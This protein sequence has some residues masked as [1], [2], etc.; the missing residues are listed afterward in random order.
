MPDT[1]KAASSLKNPPQT[2]SIAESQKLKQKLEELLS[3]QKSNS[4]VGCSRVFIEKDP[5]PESG[6]SFKPTRLPEFHGSRTR[7]PA[8]RTAVLDTFRMDW[9]LFGY[10][11]SR[12]LLMIY[13]SLR[14][15][16]LEK[17]G[18]FFE[19]GGISGTR[20]PEDFLEFLDRIYLD[21]TRVSQA[22]I[23]L[24]NLKMREGERWAD[25]FASWSNKLTEA[26]G[27]FWADENKISMLENGMNRR[28]TQ[29]LAGN[30]LL[31]DNNFSEWVRIVNKIA[32]QVE[33]ADKKLG[34]GPG[35]QYRSF[36]QSP[37]ASGKQIGEASLVEPV[38]YQHNSNDTT[39]PNFQVEQT[40]DLDAS[41]DTIMGG[42]NAANLGKKI[43]ARAK[44]KTSSELERLKE[45]KRCF[46]CERHG[47]ASRKCPLLPARR[48]SANSFRVNSAE[49]LEIDPAVYILEGNVP[50]DLVQE[51]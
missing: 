13:N 8:W 3:R 2:V 33:R 39:R 45:E 28:L 48:P 19:V 21:T 7:Y 25:F 1:Y 4:Q 38:T 10:D 30:H 43:R 42:I 9:N 51:N 41:G 20:D 29:A 34:W 12:A 31:P 27:D 40:A 37:N 32:M 22:N 36:G 14:G 11:N 47:C 5:P 35:S 23:E 26:R 24:H 17:A 49:I 44:W 18:P 15:N 16:A 6:A 46:W 50:R